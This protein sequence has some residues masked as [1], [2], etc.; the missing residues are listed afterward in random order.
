MNTEVLFKKCEENDDE[1]PIISKKPL[2]L[3][4][5]V[6]ITDKVGLLNLITDTLI[7]NLTVP[8]FSNNL[9]ALITD[10]HLDEY[11][12]NIRIVHGVIS[13]PYNP[14]G[15]Y[16]SAYSKWVWDYESIGIEP[17]IPKMLSFTTLEDLVNSSDCDNYIN[18]EFI[19]SMGVFRHTESKRI[20]FYGDDTKE[21]DY[22]YRPDDIG[23]IVRHFKRETVDTS[24]TECLYQILYPRATL[25]TGEKVTIYKSLY[26]KKQSKGAGY[27]KDD[28]YYGQVFARPFDMFWS[29]VDTEKYPNIKQ[30]NR[31]IEATPSDIKAWLNSC[32]LDILN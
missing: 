21:L 15:I 30:K 10:I 23:R 17:A 11:P 1:R 26:E 6:K 31:F 25:I 18:K 20:L 5:F 7:G 9:L 19:T 27:T 2:N 29:Q 28:I 8:E 14:N 12:N 16:T 13:Y 4:E 22:S 32:N 24:S 3:S